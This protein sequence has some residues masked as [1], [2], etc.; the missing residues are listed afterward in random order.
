MTPVSID[1]L[2]R[3][4]AKKFYGITQFPSAPMD[5]VQ[6]AKGLDENDFIGMVYR[7]NIG[8]YNSTRVITT[9]VRLDSSKVLQLQQGD[10]RLYKYDPET[11]ILSID[12]D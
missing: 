4:N 6:I 2:R 12:T 9:V 10:T 8:G 7:I 5:E 1:F 3:E 11:G